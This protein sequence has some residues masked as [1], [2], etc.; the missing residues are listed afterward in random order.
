[1]RGYGIP[2]AIFAMESHTDDIAVKLGI[3]PYE[4]RWKYLMPKD[5]RMDFQ[6]CQLL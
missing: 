1:M 2:Q 4:Y 6:K 5:I 3:P